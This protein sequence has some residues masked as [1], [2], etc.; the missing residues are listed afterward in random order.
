VPAWALSGADFFESGIG[1]LLE[2]PLGVIN[3]F[4]ELGI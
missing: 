3:A 1:I 4:L 2:Y